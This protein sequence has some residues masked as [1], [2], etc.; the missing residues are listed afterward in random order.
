MLYPSGVSLDIFVCG[1]AIT[2]HELLMVS[3]A[4][5]LYI[6]VRSGAL[7]LTNFPETFAFSF[8]ARPSFIRGELCGRDAV[9]S[10]PR[11][12][13]EKRMLVGLTRTAS[14]PRVIKGDVCIRLLSQ[15][16]RLLVARNVNQEKVTMIVLDPDRIIAAAHTAGRAALTE[17]VII[18]DLIRVITR[19]SII[20]GVRIG[21]N[22]MAHSR[23]F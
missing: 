23:A 19:R 3:S 10:N 7:S 16:R 17:M 9:A 2:T 20:D 1:V 18:N 4:R 6:R 15:R 12:R 21:I 8:S 22:L 5:S 14:N 13:T 11:V